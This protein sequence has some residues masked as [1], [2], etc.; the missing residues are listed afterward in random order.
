MFYVGAGNIPAE[1][2]SALTQTRADLKGPPTL[3]LLSGFDKAGDARRR[4]EGTP[5]VSDMSSSAL[6]QPNL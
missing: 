2:V 3:E 4:F 6:S 5:H 1:I